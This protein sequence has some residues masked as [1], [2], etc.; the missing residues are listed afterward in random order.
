MIKPGCGSGRGGGTNCCGAPVTGAEEATA[1]GAARLA[2]CC[3][4]NAAAA[5]FAAACA[6]SALVCAGVT[7]LVS[8][9]NS[10]PPAC[11]APRATIGFLLAKARRP[12][13]A[14]LPAS[15]AL[16]IMPRAVVDF[17][18]DA[19]LISGTTPLPPAPGTG[20]GSGCCVT[21]TVGAVVVTSGVTAAAADG[22]TA[23]SADVPPRKIDA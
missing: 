15:P 5:S 14:P 3:F 8:P 23:G 20:P 1:F 17:A 19:A 16:G 22:T 10:D 9:D 4:V 6:F 13:N 2:A 12:S 11:N 18:K 21:G 7:V